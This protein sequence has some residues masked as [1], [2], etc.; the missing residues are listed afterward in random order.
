VVPAVRLRTSYGPYAVRVR[1]LV[2]HHGLVA[3]HGRDEA[4][5]ERGGSLRWLLLLL[6]IPVVA[7]VV[8]QLQP[9]RT[10]S[11]SPTPTSPWSTVRSSASVVPGRIGQPTV[12]AARPTGNGGPSKVPSVMNLD[13]APFGIGGHW[14]LFASGDGVVVRIEFGHDRLTT[15]TVPS[16]DRSGP[17][18]FVATSAGAI[19][20]PL[21]SVPGYLVPDGRP[22]RQLTGVL[23]TGDPVVPG[24]DPGHVWVDLGNGVDD[25]AIRLVGPDGRPAGPDIRKP[26]NGQDWIRPD[27]AGYPLLRT[28]GGIYDLLPDGPRRVTVGVLVASGPTGWLVV[29]CDHVDRC[30]GSVV[31]RESRRRRTLSSLPAWL[32]DAQG[33]LSPDGSMAALTDVDA[34]G[35]PRLWL[36]DLRSGASSEVGAHGG[37][38]IDPGQ[39]A[40]AWSPDS[41][42]VFL[43]D[44]RGVLL[45]V[46]TA[47]GRV[48]HLGVDLPRVGQVV[49][50]SN[51]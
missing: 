44:D 25:S 46:D 36:S 20:R 24:P 48:H 12:G 33:A 51:G 17:V 37:L 23:S 28:T 3:S 27:G 29:E 47:S 2:S 39:N 10:P 9:H 41:R 50:R 22:A 30:A 5:E 7:L 15:T 40:I 19:V 35:R 8:V 34:G 4:D 31:D 42:W 11:A 32:Y 13:H 43:V 14:D 45:A 21:S 1:R 38:S 49:V 18:A 6:V 26:A 16:L